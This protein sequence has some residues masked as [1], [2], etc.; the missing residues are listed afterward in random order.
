ME[1]VLQCAFVLDRSILDRS[2]FTSTYSSQLA[3][4]I[5]FFYAS[6]EKPIF[7][8]CSLSLWLTVHFTHVTLPNP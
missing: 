4:V 5:F 1:S 8:A 2:E 7:A 3:I 6:V